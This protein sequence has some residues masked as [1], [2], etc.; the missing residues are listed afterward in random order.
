MI[1]KTVD[2]TKLINAIKAIPDKIISIVFT[3]GEKVIILSG[4]D[5]KVSITSATK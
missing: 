4:K 1:V 5:T 2:K 3:E